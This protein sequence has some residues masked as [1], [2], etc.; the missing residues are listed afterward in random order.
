MIVYVIYLACHMKGYHMSF[1]SLSDAKIGP[2]KQ[3]AT[4][5]PK[6]APTAAKPD[7]SAP[8]K[9]DPAAKS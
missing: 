2:T 8:A 1:K 3:A 4:E 6:D 9:S 7:E 5:K